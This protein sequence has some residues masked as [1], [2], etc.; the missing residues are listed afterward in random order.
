MHMTIITKEFS[1]YREETPLAREV[2]LLA[3]ALKQAGHQVSCVMPFP[4]GLD[5]AEHSL[6]R[7]LTPIKVEGD[8]MPCIR[9]DGRTA[10]G[11]NIYLLDMDN[12]EATETSAGAF[13]RAASQVAATFAI[14]PEAILS[15]G[16]E[17]LRFAGLF[18]EGDDKLRRIPQI[19]SLHRLDDAAE[20]SLGAI[21]HADRA[22]IPSNTLRPEVAAILE[23][24]R[25]GASRARAVTIPLPPT[26][27]GSD[28]DK[29]SAKAAL[30]LREGLPVRGDVPL[31]FFPQPREAVIADFVTRDVQALTVDRDG[32][33]ATLKES[34]KDR[35]ATLKAPGGLQERL[36]PADACVAGSD[37]DLVATCW[38]SGVLPIVGS[39]LSR[40]VVDLEPS[41]E[42][43]S[44]IVVADESA[45]G[46]AEAFGRLLGAFERGPA[47]GELAARLPSF[48]ATWQAVASHYT[49]LI[50]E[51]KVE[52]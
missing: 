34:Y 21:V 9:Y 5:A 14:L 13:L 29:R 41:L 8:A 28:V 46:L 17:N 2:G 26:A 12:P 50:E 51:I 22:V 18:R 39:A 19:V 48:N 40:D 52:K 7:R 27:A 43:G 49:S 33:L 4:A 11:I 16:E 35:L 45:A 23:G 6:A 32:R 24:A 3:Q 47:F 31:V 38:A 37:H 25:G 44:A 1:P 20:A 30:Q 36:G 10:E 42:T 15:F